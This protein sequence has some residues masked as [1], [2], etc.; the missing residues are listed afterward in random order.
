[1]TQQCSS[2]CTSQQSRLY[3]IGIGPFSIFSLLLVK[4][5]IRTSKYQMKYNSHQQEEELIFSCVLG[6]FFRSTYYD[7][8]FYILLR[9]QFFFTLLRFQFLHYYDYFNFQA[10]FRI[11]LLFYIIILIFKP[12]FGYFSFFT[13]KFTSICYLIVFIIC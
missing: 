9:F 1:M 3:L 7:F 5:C 13:F 11:F 8:N 6:H 12:N 10:K 4:P 2:S